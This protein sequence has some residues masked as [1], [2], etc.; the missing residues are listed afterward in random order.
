MQRMRCCAAAR[1][2]LL[3]CGL[4]TALLTSGERARADEGGVSMWVPGFFGSL[5]ATPLQPGWALATIYYHSSVDASGAAARAR[6][7]TIRRFNPNLEISLAAQLQARPDLVLF[8]PQ[9]TFA[10]PVLGGQA[11][12][13]L[14]QGVGHIQPSLD[15]V[16]QASIG[17]FSVTRFEHVFDS[18]FGFSDFGV[19]GNLR[20]NHG[21]HNFLTYAAINAPT[22]TY[23]PDRL[24]NFGIG[25]WAIDVGGGYTYFD[26]HSGYE[27]SGVLGFTYNFENPDTD[28]RNGI[29]LHFD[30]GVSKFLTK[31]W[32]IGL[33][34]YAYQQLTCDSG[35]GNRVGCFESRVFGI[36]PQLGY[37]FPMG[38]GYQGYFNAKGYKEF[39]AENRPDGWNVWLTLAISPAAQPPTPARAPTVRR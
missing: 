4:A 13:L 1:A 15:A 25:H 7:I 11:S 14:L 6:Q 24:A 8:A 23:D 5:A 26:P 21:V 22:G 39:E 19:Q 20:W 37:V 38:G 12:I 36:G 3:G 18:R 17:P 31:Q 30:W 27:L 16:I 34:G 29:D 9:Y 35:A 33:V 28:Y 2:A 10:T 32:Q